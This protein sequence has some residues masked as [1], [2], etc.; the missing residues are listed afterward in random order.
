M[1]ARNGDP[2]E[3]VGERS[4][5]ALGFRDRQ[6][7][8]ECAGPAGEDLPDGALRG[9]RVGPGRV[10]QQIL[11]TAARVEEQSQGAHIVHAVSEVSETEPG[12]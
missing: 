7:D 11:R 5:G 2:G 9:Q 10:P 1:L 3:R 4:A 12:D 8:L 6:L